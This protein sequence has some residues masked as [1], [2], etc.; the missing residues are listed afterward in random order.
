VIEIILSFLKIQITQKIYLFNRREESGLNI[1]INVDIKNFLNKMNKKFFIYSFILLLIT[2]N[3]SCSA[4]KKTNPVK[5]IPEVKKIYSEALD[6][7]E[8]GDFNESIELFKILEQNYSY[9]S[10]APKSLLMRAYI[11]YESSRYLNSLNVLKKFKERYPG[12]PN[13]AYTEYLIAMCLFDQIQLPSLSQQ[14]SILAMKQFKKI[15]SQ[16]PNSLY[17]EDAR[18]KIDLIQEQLAGK[19]MYLARFYMKKEKWISSIY[20]LQNILNNYQDT[21]F[22]DEALHR[23]VEINYKIGNIS[24]ARKYASILGYNYNNSDWY[25]KS[26]EIIKPKNFNLEKNKNKKT[27]K[28]KIIGLIK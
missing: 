10:F 28:D 22:I 20:R 5:T 19:E 13:I 2:L 25:K 17:A 21:I 6:K 3:F 11:Y 15:I 23:L 24:D 9:S 14:N 1:I 12:N 26:Y 27:F 16:Y 8:N 4:Q 18:Y 7:F